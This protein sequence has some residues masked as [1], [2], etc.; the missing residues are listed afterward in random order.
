MGDSF[1]RDP[2]EGRSKPCSGGGKVS[3]DKS[4]LVCLRKWGGI[5][6]ECESSEGGGDEPCPV[7]P[8]QPL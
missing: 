4:M 5:R 2:K 1:S 7:V 6:G 8:A 3:S